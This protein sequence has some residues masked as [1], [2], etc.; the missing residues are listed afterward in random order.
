VGLHKLLQSAAFAPRRLDLQLVDLYAEGAELLKNFRL[1]ACEEGIHLTCA[2]C[3]QI[4]ESGGRYTLSYAR[5]RIFGGI[6]A[7][8]KIRERRKR[9]DKFSVGLSQRFEFHDSGLA[10]AKVR[11]TVT[12]AQQGMAYIAKQWNESTKRNIQLDLVR[13]PI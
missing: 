1:L 4:W 6:C 9:V 12:P 3:N 13:F 2:D 7:E 10:R 5:F 8:G 11:K